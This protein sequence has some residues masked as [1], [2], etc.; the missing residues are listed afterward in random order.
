MGVRAVQ[1]AQATLDGRAAAGALARAVWARCGATAPDLLDWSLSSGQQAYA[2]LAPLVF[3]LAAS[4]AQA[5]H[6]LQAAADELASLAQALQPEVEALPLVLSGSIAERLRWRLPAAL[7]QQ[8]VA[9]MGD[10]MDGALQR[11][12]SELERMATLAQ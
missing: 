2:Q 10:A 6:L 11:L 3:D 12:Q 8:L 4:D 9:P 7:L 5:E 1:H